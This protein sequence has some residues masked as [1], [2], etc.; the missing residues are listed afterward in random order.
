MCI[1]IGGVVGVIAYRISVLAS[2]Q[3]L[4]KDQPKDNSTLG[5]TRHVITANAGIITTITAACI[6]LTIIIILNIVCTYI[7]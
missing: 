2:L 3:L 6:N 5:E 7:I 1:A 4:E